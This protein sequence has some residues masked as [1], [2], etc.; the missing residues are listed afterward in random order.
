MCSGSILEGMHVAVVHC[1]CACH[2]METTTSWHP[3][4]STRTRRQLPGIPTLLLFRTFPLHHLN[5]IS[6]Q[7]LCY[8]LLRHVRPL[9]QHLHAVLPQQRCVVPQLPRSIAKLSRRPRLPHCIRTPR[10]HH[11]FDQIVFNHLWIGQH[12]RS[13]MVDRTA[14]HTK[15]G[16]P[17]QQFVAVPQGNHLRHHC[18]PVVAMDI[19]T[20]FGLKTHI[21]QPGRTFQRMHQANPFFVLHGPGSNVLLIL[22]KKKKK[23]TKKKKKSSVVVSDHKKQ[24]RRLL[25]KGYL[26]FKQQIS[27]VGVVGWRFRFAGIKCFLGKAFRPGKR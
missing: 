3:P 24:R 26:G 11:R 25:S 18:Q 2:V 5:H 20:G 21:F 7:Q 10:V 6:C 4:Q 23:Q 13:W 22:N 9:L 17:L 15:F 8:F 1:V 27:S 14:G 19:A 12:S 16:Q